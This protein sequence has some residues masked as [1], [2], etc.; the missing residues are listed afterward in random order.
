MPFINR[1]NGQKVFFDLVGGE[2]NPLI[3]T[4][5]GWIENSGY[6]SRSGISGRLAQAGW[7]V[8][9]M[10]MRGH[11]KSFPGSSPDYSIESIVEDISAVADSLG[12]QKFHLLTHATGGM[13][14]CRYA[15]THPERLLSMTASDTASS[16]A[17][18]PEYASQEWDS[19][20]I[21]PMEGNPGADNCAWLKSVG[22][23]ADMMQSLSTD[24]NNHPLGIFFQ[25][26]LVNKD[27]ERCWRWTRELYDTNVL[28]Y[29][30]DFAEGFKF[31]DTDRHVPALSRLDFPVLAMAGELDYALVD[32]TKAIAR[33]V[34]GARLHIF[35]GIGHMTAIEDADATFETILEFMNSIK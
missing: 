9:D 24:T 32:F 1:E 17:L 35:K 23:F 8:A 11:G 21:P 22:S 5:H 15:V 31:N 18:I 12:A 33:N 29:T 27:P 7:R 25:G 20:P 28:D 16:T 26:F 10:D 3:I 2:N 30:A 19:K 34:P 6:W 13:V 14:G 4:T